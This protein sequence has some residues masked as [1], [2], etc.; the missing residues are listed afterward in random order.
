MVAAGQSPLTQFEIKPLIPIQIGDLDVSFTNASAFMVLAV[1]LASVF[2]IAGVKRNAAVPGRW[3]S[4]AELIYVFIGN[5]VRDTIGSEGRAYFPLIFTIFI[6]ILFGNLLGMIPYGFTFTS[7]IIVTFVLAAVIFIGV[8][9]LALYKHGFHFFSFFLP[10]GV[11]MWTAP[12]LL[13]IEIISYFVRPVSLSLRL[14][15]NMMAGHTL[16]KVFAG[17]VVLLGIAGVVPLVF[18]VLLTG[19][20]IMIA[21]LQAYVFTILTCLYIND[22]LHLH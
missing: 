8:T 15:A 20:E 5:L 2:L 22:A 17:F 11:P 1:V 7:H 6:F 18:V 13:P 14:A 16:L 19:L 9:L 21:C 10:P 3:Q 12:L 4:M